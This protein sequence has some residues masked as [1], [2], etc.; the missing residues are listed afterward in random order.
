[1]KIAM[2]NDGVFYTLQ[3][4][5]PLIGKPA[6]FVRTTGCNAK[7]VWCDT[8]YTTFPD[9]LE[10]DVR[11]TWAVADDIIELIKQHDCHLIVFTGGEPMLQQ[12]A[13]YQIAELAQAGTKQPLRIQFETNGSIA[14]DDGLDWSRFDT[15]WVV[16]PKEAFAGNEQLDVA[17]DCSF[18]RADINSVFKVVHEFNSPKSDQRIF[19]LMNKVSRELIDRKS[20]RLNSS[21]EFVSRMPSSA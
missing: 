12:K 10:K 17:V 16:S 4:E 3:G 11:D 15:C 6:I 5:G 1:M 7:C 8:P 19:D 9:Q 21:H 20:T 13:L 18:Y 2:S 14:P